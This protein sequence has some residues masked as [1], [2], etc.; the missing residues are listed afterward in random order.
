MMKLQMQLGVVL[1]LNVLKHPTIAVL[2]TR[3]SRLKELQMANSNIVNRAL[4][5]ST[6]PVV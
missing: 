2:D 5:L 6:V 3:L 1:I 4:V